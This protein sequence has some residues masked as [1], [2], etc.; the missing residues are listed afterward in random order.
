[1]SVLN[2][3][4]GGVHVV[5]V[6]LKAEYADSEGETA[7]QL[8]H[9]LG[10]SAAKELRVSR[11]YLLKGP[12]TVAHAQQAAR[13]LLTDPV[14]QEFKLLS[15]SSAPVSNGM[16]HWRVEVWLKSTVS[17]PA[18]D[19]VRE[20]IAEMGLPEP[21]TVRVGTAYRIAGRV[22]RHQLEKAVTRSLANPVVHRVAVS[23]AHP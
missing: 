20:A 21:S 23:E 3:K 8:L 17:D 13:D 7:L 2:G 19:T 10:V 11:L 4:S 6:R 18:G 16:S 5:E 9:G 15:P 1:M 22:G 14:T 12:L